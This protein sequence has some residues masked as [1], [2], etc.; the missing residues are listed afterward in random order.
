M[1]NVCRAC[2][3]DENKA[4]LTEFSI[5]SDTFK[6][7]QAL[8]VSEVSKH[9]FLTNFCQIFSPI[10]ISRGSQ[11]VQFLLII[12]FSIQQRNFLQHSATNALQK[13]PQQQT[14][15]NQAQ[16]QKNIFFHSCRRSMR[17]L[18]IHFPTLV[19]IDSQMMLKRA[20]LNVR[21]KILN[22]YFK[23]KKSTSNNHKKFKRNHH[24]N[25]I[26]QKF[27]RLEEEQLQHQRQPARNFPMM[28]SR[29]KR[30]F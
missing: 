22:I 15:S 29:R 11:S 2:L 24:F 7:F 23:K 19:A 14:S 16:I 27:T 28:M 8:I 21:N 1:S 30:H 4:K 5:E 26:S 25:R 17:N 18:K 13:S 12:F 6:N 3:S 10:I 9:R 20:Q